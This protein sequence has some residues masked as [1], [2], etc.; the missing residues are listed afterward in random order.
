MQVSEVM[1]SDVKLVSPS[2]RIVEVARIMKEGDLGAIPVGENDRLKGMITDRDIILRGIAEGKSIQDCTVREVMSEGIYYCYED[3][4][5]ETV[6]Q[7]MA[8]A[9][10]RRLPVLNRD[11]RMVGI[12]S[13]GDLAGA[14]DGQRYVF[15]ALKR[16]TH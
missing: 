11:K 6:S 4:D 7:K 15:Q 10:I 12:V 14:D 8:E 16:I 3:D 13:L 2:D 9:K 1:S 5:L